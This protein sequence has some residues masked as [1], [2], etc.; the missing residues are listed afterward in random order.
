[1]GWR[2]LLAYLV[3]GIALAGACSGGGQADES[4][5]A[6]GAGGP[7]DVRSDEELPEPAPTEADLDETGIGGGSAG[8]APLAAGRI[9]VVDIAGT[10]DLV[11]PTTGD[12]GPA[13]GA[14]RRKI[15]SVRSQPAWSPDGARLAWTESAA[16]GTATLVVVDADGSEAVETPLVSFFNLWDPTSGHVAALGAIGGEV[17]LV[18]STPRAGDSVVSGELLVDQPLFIS[19]SPDGE[20]LVAHSAGIVR[21]LDRDG[22]VGLTIAASDLFQTPMWIP[23]TDSFIAVVPHPAGGA[24]TVVDAATGEQQPLAVV[25]GRVSMTL[26][27]SGARLGLVHLPDVEEVVSIGFTQAQT[28]PLGLGLYVIELGT[29]RTSSLVAGGRAALFWSPQ[30]DRILSLAAAAAD[31]PFFLRWQV[32]DLDGTLVAQ[33]PPMR[34]SLLMAQ[35]YLPFADQYAQTMTPWAPDGSA[36]AY[37]GLPEGEAPGIWVHDVA[38]DSSAFLTRGDA[39]V[40]SPR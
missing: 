38:T 39:A 35:A 6:D 40:W 25:S 32:H 22:S 8:A 17:G 5:A 1:M 18:V 26:D 7:E 36:F 13:P 37:A 19:W 20:R 14:E 3:V 24:V 27:P 4:S 16:D 2:R 29:G 31:D 34:P 11:D 10:I 33:T 9:A 15:R 30:G 23:G 28:A 12:R 21:V